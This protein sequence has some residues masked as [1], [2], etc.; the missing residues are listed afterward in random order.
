MKEVDFGQKVA[1]NDNLIQAVTENPLVR[2][3]SD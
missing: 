2:S 1:S 3:S